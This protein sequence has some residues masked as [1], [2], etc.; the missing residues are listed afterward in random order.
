MLGADLLKLD[1][2]VR[3][4]QNIQ[5]VSGGN[6]L[7]N[8]RSAVLALE[9]IAAVETCLVPEAGEFVFFDHPV[10]LISH[11][12]EGLSS[13]RHFSSLDIGSD[14]PMSFFHVLDPPPPKNS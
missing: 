14:N 13:P 4:V 1:D 11:L 7:E 6:F 9:A 12:S 8:V 5:P 2:A 3:L 10:F